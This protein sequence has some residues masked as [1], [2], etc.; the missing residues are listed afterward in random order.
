MLLPFVV[1]A[2]VSLS[3]HENAEDFGR[4]HAMVEVWYE[5]VAPAAQVVGVLF[6]LMD[7]VERQRQPSQDLSERRKGLLESTCEAAMQVIFRAFLV[8][9]VRCKLSDQAIS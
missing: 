4:S 6:G 1:D 7:Q 5:G 8:W 2:F 3:S 9:Y